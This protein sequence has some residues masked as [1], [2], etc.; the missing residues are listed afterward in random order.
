MRKRR[1]VKTVL[2]AAVLASCLMMGCKKDTSAENQLKYREE[3]IEC[4]DKQEYDKA[5]KAFQKALDES[6]GKISHT[7]IDICYYKAAAL[8]AS[9]DVEGAKETYDALLAYDKKAA[10]AYYLRGTLYLQEKKEEEALADYEKASIYAETNLDIYMG[11][12]QS[13][14]DAGLDQQAESYA[15]KAAEIVPE[16]SQERT[17]LGQ[18]YLLQGKLDEAQQELEKA[19]SEGDSQANLYLAKLYFSDESPE[20]A[21]EY[22]EAYAEANAQDANALNRVGELLLE[23]GKAKEALSYFQQ[24]LEL[25]KKSN[26]Q[27]LRK[28]EIVALEHEGEYDSAK[29]KITEYCK[30]YP[31]DTEAQKE[32]IFL[33][34][35]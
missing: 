24:G 5:A 19:V 6:N 15:Q 1:T 25:E 12:C 13:L 4:M 33:S 8:A 26:E 21:I 17:K 9:G 27:T 23:Q 10:E 14:T 7:E 29:E 28:N 2:I 35:R 3:G 20:E 11:I 18:M 30:K 32:E 34:T 16:T 22:C 31:D